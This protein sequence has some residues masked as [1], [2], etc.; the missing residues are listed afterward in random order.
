ARTAVVMN[1]AAALVAA[2]AADDL[3]GGAALAAQLLDSGAVLAKLDA[4]RAI[5]PAPKEAAP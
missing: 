3:K 4:L 2:E 1:A 5:Q